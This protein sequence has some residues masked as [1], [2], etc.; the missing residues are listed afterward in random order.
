MESFGIVWCF[1]RACKR[2]LFVVAGCLPI[3]KSNGQGNSREQII[4]YFSQTGGNPQKHVVIAI[5]T[6]VKNRSKL[7]V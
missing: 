3:P 7:P 4:S 5:H 6:I 2:L 1:Y